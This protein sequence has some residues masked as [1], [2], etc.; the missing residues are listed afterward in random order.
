MVMS[1]L[2]KSC[3][4]TAFFV[5]IN[6]RSLIL[7]LHLVILRHEIREKEDMGDAGTVVDFYNRPPHRRSAVFC[8]YADCTTIGRKTGKRSE[9]RHTLPGFYTTGPDGIH[10]VYVVAEKQD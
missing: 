5:D 7:A 1:R 9:C 8:L 4:R 10:R 3:L 2:A 6:S